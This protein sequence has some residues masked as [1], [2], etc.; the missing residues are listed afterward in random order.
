MLLIALLTFTPLVVPQGVKD[1]MLYGVPYTL[2]VGFL[3]AVVLV[4][5]T[6]VG[7][8]LHPGMDEEQEVGS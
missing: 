2:W 1:P 3:Q 5:L 4:A 6:Y 8:K 7:T